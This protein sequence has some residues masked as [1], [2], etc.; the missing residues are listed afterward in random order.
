MVLET[1]GK[2]EA[3]QAICDKIDYYDSCGTIELESA[4]PFILKKFGLYVLCGKNYS[5]DELILTTGLSSGLRRIRP[6]I[7]VDPGI[8]Y[9]KHPAG[10]GH[11][12]VVE[13]ANLIKQ[14]EYTF[15]ISDP[16]PMKKE[17]IIPE[18]DLSLAWNKSDNFML[19]ILDN[20]ETYRIIHNIIK[21]K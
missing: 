20:G 21:K 15:L 11:A 2:I 13:R 19:F 5:L 3:E 7:G 17:Q 8:I 12:I 14:K 4:E 10:H 16:D 18:K 6:I 9:G 1:Y